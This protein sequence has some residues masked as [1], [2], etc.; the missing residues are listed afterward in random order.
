MGG[1]EF[2]VLLGD[3]SDDKIRATDLASNVAEKI[4]AALS[5][6]YLL[7]ITDD[8]KQDA[9]VEHCCTASIGVMLFVGQDSSQAVIL[10]WADKAMYLAKKNGGNLVRISDIDAFSDL[11]AH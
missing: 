9:E 4:R 5:V 10:N 7:T 6:P 2:I 1:D 8:K 11:L 3:L